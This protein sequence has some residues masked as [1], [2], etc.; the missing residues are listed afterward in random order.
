MDSEDE[1]VL[2]EVP[3]AKSP[4]VEPPPVRAPLVPSKLPPHPPSNSKA[5]NP[6]ASLPPVPASSPASGAA[7]GTLPAPIAPASA[8]PPPLA[9]SIPPPPSE[10]L[11]AA[12][13]HPKG[14]NTRRDRTSQGRR[15]RVLAAKI[16]ALPLA[17]KIAALP[18]IVKQRVGL[19][20]F[21]F[22]VVFWLFYIGREKLARTAAT[23]SARQTASMKAMSTQEG[24]ILV[25]DGKR[26]GPL[27]LELADL[28]PGEHSIVLEGDRYEPQKISVTLAAG[29]VRELHAPALRVSQGVATF[30]VRTPGASLALVAPDE[31]RTL[32]D[33]SHPVAFDN[34]KPWALEAS[35][36]GYQSV[37][38]PITFEDQAERTFVVVLEPL[39][40]PS[41]M[42]GS[43][44]AESVT[45]SPA[46][47]RKRKAARSVA[48]K[49]AEPN[50]SGTCTL[51]ITS[52]PV[53]LVT[54]DGRTIG[55][56]PTAG[57]SVPAGTHSVMF[58]SGGGRRA[59]VTTCKA[60][61][62]KTMS[63]RLPR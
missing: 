61:E 10:P 32:L 62:Q 54:L 22:V 58:M 15:E 46:A 35:K 6:R 52:V 1:R 13:E 8:P 23:P 39:G 37:T 20:G 38:F 45:D 27:P 53:S 3:E 59:T 17:A 28:T 56:T 21:A 26:V 48:P 14:W 31:R 5:A 36:P 4:E 50:A 42:E 40:D 63:V 44:S 18:P 9:T 55:L 7:P 33:Y 19:I 60:G 34:S 47:H 49:V 24:V 2:T 57:I 12:A 29:E 11:R 25:A 51:T 30:D 41:E 43:P 16:A